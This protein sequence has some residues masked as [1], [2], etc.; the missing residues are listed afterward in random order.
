MSA[1]DKERWDQRYREGFYADRPYPVAFLQAN[2]NR[3]L[4][5]RALD[6][7]CGSGRNAQFLAQHGFSVVGL[8]ISNVALTLAK[9]QATEQDLN[10]QYLQHDL[11]EELPDLGQFDL[12]TI[13][14]Y[15]NRPLLATIDQY[16]APHGYLLIELHLRYDLDDRPLAGPIEPEYRMQTKEVQSRLKNVQVEFSF[17][18]IIKEPDDRD[19]AVTQIIAYKCV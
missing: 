4:P 7:A 12:I 3:F 6:I 1:Q 9:S 10:I 2:I 16:L 15:A 17:E 19:A 8:D 18:G 13:I 11:D 5:G 14:R